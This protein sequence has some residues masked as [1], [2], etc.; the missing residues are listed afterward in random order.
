MKKFAFIKANWHKNIV[1]KSLD[2]FLS[3]IPEDK[4]DIYEVPGAFELP[5]IAQDLAKTG[6]YSAIIASAFVVDGGIYRHEFVAQSVVK[7]LLDT[8]LL[9]KTPILSVSLTPHK[10]HEN[11]SHLDFFLDHFFLK[12]I[13]AANSAKSI[14]NERDR[15]LE[16]FT[17]N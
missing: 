1:D 10:F 2:G 13:E 17:K 11:Q 3:I 6:H 5:L 8:S 12:G 14:I 15:I 7:G 9:T 16:K 4:V